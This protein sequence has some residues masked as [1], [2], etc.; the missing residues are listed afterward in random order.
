MRGS[1]DV[2]FISFTIYSMESVMLTTTC[3]RGSYYPLFHIWDHIIN[4]LVFKELNNW[5]WP[6][7]LT[8]Y[9]SEGDKKESLDVS[10]QAKTNVYQPRHW[11]NV[12]YFLIFLAI[13]TIKTSS[14]FS[15]TVAFVRRMYCITVCPLTFHNKSYSDMGARPGEFKILQWKFSTSG[16]WTEMC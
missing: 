8:C 4:I 14:S 6:L 10:K 13:A 5:W 2:S 12:S 3:W 7:W 1:G 11:Q 15:K 16:V 9:T